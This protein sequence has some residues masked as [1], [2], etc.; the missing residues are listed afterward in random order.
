MAAHQSDLPDWI[1]EGQVQSDSRFHDYPSAAPANPRRSRCRRCVCFISLG[2]AIAAIVVGVM[3]GITKQSPQQLYNDARGFLKGMEGGGFGSSGGGSGDDSSAASDGG[4]GGYA[5][6]EITSPAFDDGGPCP[7]KYTADGANISP[8]LRWSTPP[9]GTRS[10]ALIMSD[11]QGRDGKGYTHWFVTNIPATSTELEEGIPP[12]ASDRSF[13]QALND[14]NVAGYS[15]PKPPHGS[16]EHKYYFRIF[17]FDGSLSDPSTRTRQELEELL[18]HL[19]D[20]GRGEVMCT[21]SG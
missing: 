20:I 13:H 3:L 5:T 12:N 11:P 18:G 15:G 6:L 7:V 16:G 1:G 14:G 8:P 19:N 9:S 10:L 4:T 2:L 21:Y 17:A